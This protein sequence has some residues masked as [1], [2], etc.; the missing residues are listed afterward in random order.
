MPQQ[1]DD[2]VWKD[3]VRP[4]QPGGEGPGFLCVP[5]ECV[6]SLDADEPVRPL[7]SE[8]ARK[9][10]RLAEPMGCAIYRLEPDRDL[11]QTIEEVRAALGEDTPI[12][13]HYVFRS[14]PWY[15][16]GPA[17]PPT[18]EP[19]DR[20][21]W[22]PDG[23]DGI[24]VAV[25]DSGVDVNHPDLVDMT[26]VHES[27][28]VTDVVD[29]NGNNFADYLS[30][31]GTFIA[32]IYRSRVP[33]CTLHVWRTLSSHGFVSEEQLCADLRAAIALN[34][35][36]INLSLGGYTLANQVPMGL[37]TVLLPATSTLVVAAAGNNGDPTKFYPAALDLAHVVAVGAVAPSGP[38]Y[39]KTDYS[40][41]G[42]WVGCCAV[43]ATTGP[44]VTY[45]LPREARNGVADPGTAS[46]NFEGEAG[47]HGT[48]FATPLVGARAAML[49]SALP[50]RLPF[51]A[52][53]QI[54]SV[55]DTVNG[56]GH[57]ITDELADSLRPPP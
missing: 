5:Q 41:F 47:W 51:D 15:E 39:Q 19:I 32:G 21:A 4:I 45:D 36:V 54:R 28:D 38:G 17:G 7:L 35:A 49:A 8:E 14:Q 37:M 9:T 48:S 20:G 44:F 40:N 22:R 55:A 53:A 30:G 24:H 27:G 11:L 12:G 23:G 16:G 56:V 43:G 46:Q 57:H 3:Q 25:L 29:D 34:P 1:D 52:L 18:V 26:I 31:H 13:P 42:S 6:V 50:N 2:W 33:E 10:R